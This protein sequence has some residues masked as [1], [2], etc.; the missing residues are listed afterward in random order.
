MVVVDVSEV[1][2]V[3]SGDEVVILGMQGGCQISAEDIGLKMGT[4]NYEVTTHINPL[5]PRIIIK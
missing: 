1:L 3:S 2:D 5:L 4:I